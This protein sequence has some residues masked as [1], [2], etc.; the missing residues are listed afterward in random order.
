MPGFDAGTGPVIECPGSS[1]PP[2]T[3]GTCS[4]TPGSASRLITGVIL[5]PDTVYKGGQVLFDPDG[6]IQCVGCDCSSMSEAASA[7]RVVCPEGVVSPGL[8][9]SHDHI[10]Y[11]GGPFSGFTSERYEHRHDWRMGQDGHTKLLSFVS[12]SAA[13]RWAELRQVMAGTTS[14]AGGDGE[15]G[16]LRN[17]DKPSTS[18]SGGNQEGLGA[19]VS[20]L[21]YQTF[22]LGDLTGTELTSGCAY[23]LIDP[24]SDIPSDS[25][26]LAHVAE[27]IETS[28]FNEF[29]CTSGVDPS[30]QELLGPRTAII[31]GIGLRVPEIGRMASRGASLVWSP[32]SNVALYGDTAQVA[33]HKRMGVNVALGTDWL[34]T[35]SMNLLREL[36]CADYLNSVYYN[37]TFSDAELWSL[38]TRNAARATRT[39]SKIGDL[40]PGRIA[41]IAIFRLNAFEH[42]PHRAVIAANPED[43]V[44]TLRGGKPLYGDSALVEALGATG[45]DALEVCG[46]S[47]RVCLQSETSESLA[48]L[49]SQNPGAYPLFFCSTAP[50]DEPP[51]TPSRAS[52]DSR[53]PGSVNGSTSYSGIPELHDIDGDGVPDTLDN[54][55][56]FFNPVRPLDNGMQADLD[57]DRVGD[58]CDVCPLDAYTTYCASHYPSDAD[59]DGVLTINDNCP[60]TYNPGQEDSDGDG[61]GNAC[62]MCPVS[63][64]DGAPCPVSIYMLKTSASGSWPWVGQRVSLHDVLVT[65]AGTSGFFVQVHPDEPGYSGPGYS[66]LFVYEPGHTVKVGDRVD[67]GNALVTNYFGQLQVTDPASLAIR[68]SDNALPVPI[69]VATW[70]VASGGWRARELEGV[71]VRVRGLEV[72]EVEPLPGPGDVSPTHEFVVDGVLRVN[73]L[74]FR[75]PMPAVGDLYASITGVLQWRNGNSKLEPRSSAD[76]VG[77]T[78]PFLVEFGPSDGTFVR[79]GY[80]GPTFPQEILVTLSRPAEVDTFV[81]V[82]SYNSGVS[83]P[84]GGVLVPAGQRS[85]PLWVN[86]DLSAAGAYTG[87]TALMA[88]LDGVSRTASVNVLSKDWVSWMRSVG[89]ERTTLEQGGEMRC[90]VV[91]EVPPGEAT[92]VSL[93]VSPGGLGTVPST[94]S[95]PARQLSA[96]FVFTASSSLRGVGNLVA[97]LGSQT[98]STWIEVIAPST[99]DH[100][101][102]SE[103]APQGPGGAASD[104]FIE[105]YNPTGDEVDLSGWKLQYKSSTGSTY[106]SSYV[107]PAGVRIASHGFF[108]VTASGYT[109]PVAGDAN[110]GTSLRL[111]PDGGHVR[112]G[113][114]GIGSSPADPLAVDT[115]GYGTA[116]NAAE[117]S[118]VPTLPGASGSFE[119]KAWSD[120]TGSSME[121]GDHAFHGNGFDSNDNS[122]DFV[123]RGS[124]DPRNR[125][126]P[127]EP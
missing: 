66:G 73:D 99:T 59:S 28:A 102:I 67:I 1:L 93:A 117:G 5:A 78:I 81:P 127:R 76:L 90:S 92:S 37:A 56:N 13:I 57:G 77:D 69:D 47:R 70:E 43:V 116:A 14:I 16:L 103:F 19:G 89:C 115:V 64:P 54:C 104:E 119:R 87:S 12:S 7:T 94:V 20:G 45:C 80:A 85:A 118:P 88:T 39:S 32:R 84:M 29:L 41:D 38:V 6:V 50:S 3:S 11:Q 86:V 83:V 53:F 63:N 122:Q 109:G 30:G 75:A 113:K 15:N 26:Y 121:F 22:P 25:A 10:A 52:T 17:L 79:E 48:A 100:V 125:A 96:S 44:L 23:P 33:I 126:S 24:P 31:Q 123:L 42:S 62:D 46:A 97:T 65:G 40:S 105:L 120:S 112:L 91:L 55:P 60:Y 34:T 101:V 74:L 106:S 51:C 110:W 36:R 58:A 68:G 108:L 49:Q 4:V 61:L 9:N 21:N 111:S 107:L 114:P 2:P 71:L 18:T 98:R 72:T 124:R 27:G 8:I 95:I 35:G 82:T